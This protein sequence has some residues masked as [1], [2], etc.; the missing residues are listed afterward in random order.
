M[1]NKFYNFYFIVFIA[2]PKVRTNEMILVL[3]VF[4][5]ASGKLESVLPTRVILN[6]IFVYFT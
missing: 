2:K 3:T 5:D 6:F 4:G 1:I